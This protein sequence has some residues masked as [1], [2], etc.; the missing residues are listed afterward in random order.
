MYKLYQVYY[1]SS[2]V[3]F[4]KFC[5]SIVFHCVGLREHVRRTQLRGLDLLLSC[6]DHRWYPCRSL[7][8]P[9]GTTVCWYD[10]TITKLEPWSTFYASPST[11]GS[12]I[13]GTSPP[14]L[15]SYLHL[16]IGTPCGLVCTN[17][18]ATAYQAPGKN[19]TTEANQRPIEFVYF[20]KLCI[21]IFFSTQ[22]RPLHFPCLTNSAI[23][24]GLS[25]ILWNRTSRKLATKH[26]A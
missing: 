25:P 21:F 15:F 1:S 7:L 23:Q 6:A 22:L 19:M 26:E 3:L 5:K 9:L 13:P 18:L 2:F 8:V 20:Y 17:C 12:T 11:H 4:L 10:K 16:A 24:H 14:R